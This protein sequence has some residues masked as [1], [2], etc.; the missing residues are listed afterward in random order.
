MMEWEN[1][2]YQILLRR[3]EAEAVLEDW[4]AREVET[5]IRVRKAKTKGCVVIEVTDTLYANHIRMWHP[6][7][8]INIKD[9]QPK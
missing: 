7:C 3:Q 8:K 2:L 6:D 1:K 9:I 4:I 5:D